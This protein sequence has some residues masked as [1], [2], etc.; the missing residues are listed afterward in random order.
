MI[1]I[2]VQYVC[3]IILVHCIISNQYLNQHYVGQRNGHC[4]EEELNSVKV[5]CCQ[6]ISVL[7]ST[8]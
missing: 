5:W 2:L 1:I 8:L 3:V 4:S 6:S 7:H